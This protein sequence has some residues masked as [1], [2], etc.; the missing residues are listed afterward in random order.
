MSAGDA[1]TNIDLRYLNGSI[2]AFL[3]PLLNPGT[4]PTTNYT[5]RETV[6]AKSDPGETPQLL[7]F[8]SGGLNFQMVGVIS[9]PT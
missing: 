4:S 3:K 7:T 5:V 8:V 2:Q 6:P 9:G 1:I